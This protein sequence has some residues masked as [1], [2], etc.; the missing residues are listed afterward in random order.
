MKTSKIL[1]SSVLVVAVL[2]GPFVALAG[3][4]KPAAKPKPYTLKKCVVS[5]EKLGE[6]GK[7]FVFTYEGREI[8][9]CCPDCQ[10]NFKKTPAKYVKKIEEEEAKAKK[11]KT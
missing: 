9:L 7:P 6:M 10:K 3:D 2:A 5:G 4:E 1:T 11:G 8:K